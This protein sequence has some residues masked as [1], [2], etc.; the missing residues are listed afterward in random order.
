MLLMLVAKE[1]IDCLNG[2]EGAKRDFNEDGR[3]IAHCTIP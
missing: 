1:I 3:P 2:V